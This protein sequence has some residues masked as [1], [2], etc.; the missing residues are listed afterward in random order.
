MVSADAVC[1]P[2]R[3]GTILGIARSI[4]NPT[5]R[6]LV[7]AEPWLRLAVPTL[8]SIFLLSLAVSAGLQIWQSRNVTLQDASDG[9]DVIATLAAAKLQQPDLSS[10]SAAAR[11]LDLLAR[12][13][14]ASAFAH[15]RTLLLA[16]NSGL[17]LAAHPA[18]QPV[19]QRL[20]DFQGDIQLLTTYGDRAG[21][22]GLRLGADDAIATLRRLPG[23]TGQI[24]VVQPV[25]SLLS[26]W[27]TRSYGLVTLV[28]AVVIVLVG[29]AAAYFMQA[30][31]AR[32]ADEVCEKVR[33]RVDSALARGRCGLLDWDIARGRMY[34][35]DSMYELLGYERHDEFLSFG[36]VNAMVHPDDGDLYAL[37]DQLASS[38]TSA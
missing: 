36:Q 30:G 38:R 12:A 19:P 15:G 34:W 22:V 4:A 13:L 20:S 18:S 25:E 26:G 6:R 24:A 17:I 27:R 2:V 35:S 37:A 3:T 28:G 7:H 1:E 21:V 29:I 9:I 33:R 11:D 10:R 14:P 8:L 16:D 5:Y 23:G 31:R 32:A